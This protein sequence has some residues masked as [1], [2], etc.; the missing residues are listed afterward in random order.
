MTLLLPNPRPT[1]SNRATNATTAEFPSLHQGLRSAF[2][3]ALGIQGDS[4]RD[5]VFNRQLTFASPSYGLR[6][7]YIS[8]IGNSSRE[9]QGP[10]VPDYGLTHS[11]TIAMLGA[12][13]GSDGG[14]CEC[15]TGSINTGASLFYQGGDLVFRILAGGRNTADGSVGYTI[16]H[17]VSTSIIGTYDGISSNQIIWLNGVNVA[18]KTQGGDFDNIPFDEIVFMSLEASVFNLLGWVSAIYLWDRALKLNEIQL[19]ADPLAPFR[20]RATRIFFPD[21]EAAAVEL[22]TLT[23]LGVGG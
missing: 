23:L 17:P 19:L 4:P 21:Q 22:K 12:I 11:C 5:F 2:V 9:V 1:L 13:T 15:S 20:R 18:S 7:G 16:S 14:F 6:D 8:A 3:P 10:V